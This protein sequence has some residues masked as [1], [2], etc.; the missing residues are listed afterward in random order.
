MEDALEALDD[1]DDDDA[2]PEEDPPEELED[3]DTPGPTVRAADVQVLITR[4][5]SA[6]V[7]PVQ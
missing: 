5:P 7:G 6:S 4:R 3:D 1:A 2:M